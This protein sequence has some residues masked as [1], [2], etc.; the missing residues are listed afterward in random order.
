MSFLHKPTVLMLL[1]CCSCAVP[2]LAQNTVPDLLPNQY[3]FT[4][5]ANISAALVMGDSIDGKRQAIPITGGVVHGADIN[6]EVIA[7]GADYQ[8]E[9]AD[10][11]RQLS[12]VYMIRTDDGAVINVI[13]SGLVVAP[14]ISGHSEQYFRAAPVFTAPMGK[15]G[16]LNN[17]IFIAGVRFNPEQP[18]RVLI[19]VYKVL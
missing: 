9:R 17:N 5:E 13:N 2:A 4:I 1:I 18:D 19:D 15:Y 16:W 3:V 8:L 14:G 7:G 6:G 11:S 12:A 10:G